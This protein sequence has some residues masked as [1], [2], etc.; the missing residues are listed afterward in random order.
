VIREL[1]AEGTT[2][3]LTTQ[4]LEE[5]DQSAQ[6]VAVI[7]QGRVIAS[8]TPDELKARIG[9][10]VLEVRPAHPTDL[11]RAAGLLGELTGGQA[12]VDH[13]VRQLSLPMPDPAWLP[14]AVRWLDEA[15]IAVVDLA[16]RRPSLD[17]VFLALTGRPA[18]A[19]APE[20]AP[21]TE[22]SAA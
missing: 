12:T 7:D 8:G 21:T 16:L 9:G 1:V 13:D 14:V 15:G 11:D 19:A 18:E 5:A 4:Y 17:E 20:Q 2:V 3:L 22:R 6:Q 10:Q